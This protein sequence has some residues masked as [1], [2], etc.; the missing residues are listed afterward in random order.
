MIFIILYSFVDRTECEQI[1]HRIFVSKDTIRDI[2]LLSDNRTVNASVKVGCVSKDYTLNGTS[3]L[4]CLPGG[5]WSHPIPH[6]LPRPPAIEGGLSTQ[7]KIIIGVGVT[8]G[9]TLISVLILVIVLVRTQRIEAER[10]KEKSANNIRTGIDSPGSEFV[11]SRMVGMYSVYSV[12]RRQ[13]V[14]ITANSVQELMDKYQSLTATEPFR[15]VIETNGMLVRSDSELELNSHRSLMILQNGERWSHQSETTGQSDF[16]PRFGLPYPDPSRQW[17]TS[18]EVAGLQFP[19]IQLESPDNRKS[20]E[21]VFLGIS[22]EFDSHDKDVRPELSYLKAQTQTSSANH[23]DEKRKT[24]DSSYPTRPINRYSVE[25]HQEQCRYAESAGDNMPPKYKIPGNQNPLHN[26]NE[27]HS[28]VAVDRIPSFASPMNRSSWLLSHRQISSGGDKTGLQS[29]V[30]NTN[31]SDKSLPQFSNQANEDWNMR[32]RVRTGYNPCSG[33]DDEFIAGDD[34]KLLKH[35]R[36][37]SDVSSRMDHGR[38]M[39]LRE[40]RPINKPFIVTGE[41]L[42]MNE[43]MHNQEHFRER[44][45][46]KVSTSLRHGDVLF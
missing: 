14:Y 24:N 23:S 18:M 5:E 7:N 34:P 31:L 16:T 22:S 21:S 29:N 25:R 4:T 9:F 20:R 44:N 2:V 8:A 10:L 13:K 3:V 35:Q 17:A 38:G 28:C 36:M 32:T 39:E 6:C 11:F 37:E 33:F 43:N 19:R 45:G 1:T 46:L 42:S 40:L 15:L 30:H 41:N 27:S 12:S 26:H